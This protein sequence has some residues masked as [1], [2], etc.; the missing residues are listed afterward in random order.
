MAYENYF[1]IIKTYKYLFLVGF[2]L[3][4]FLIIFKPHTVLTLTL[5][6][7]SGV[8]VYFRTEY[9][10]PV[11]FTPTIF[12]AVII[13]LVA[14]IPSMIFYVIFGIAV[15]TIIT[16]FVNPH[17]LISWGVMIGINLIVP[18]ISNLNII[19]IGVIICIIKV[20]VAFITNLFLG[21]HPAEITLS[22]ITHVTINMVLFIRL[23]ELILNWSGFYM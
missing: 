5:T 13:T 18:F 22:E 8:V 7:I 12:C 6:L 2:L 23:G 21:M 15:P 19:F 1:E 14:G 11:D 16:G 20:L 10:I 4:V 17:A 3:L 9:Q